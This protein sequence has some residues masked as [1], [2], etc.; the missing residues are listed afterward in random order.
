MSTDE[1][2]Y[3]YQSQPLLDEPDSS[4]SSEKDVV[5]HDFRDFL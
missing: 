2:G 1:H 4:K 3:T 5:T